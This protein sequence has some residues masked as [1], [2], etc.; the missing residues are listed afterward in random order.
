MLLN[1]VVS[2]STEVAS[3]RSRTAKARS[4]A[5]LLRAPP[6]I[7]RIVVPWLAGEMRQGRIGV[8]YSAIGAALETPSAAEPRWT[9]AEV[10]EIDTRDLLKHLYSLA[11][12]QA[13]D[14]K[15]GT[16]RLHDVMRKYLTQ[17]Q[18]SE[19]LKGLH[20]QFVEAYDAAS[21]PDIEDG[22]ERRYFYTWFPTHLHGYTPSARRTG[23]HH[24]T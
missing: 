18:A 14:L 7:L 10:D 16:V 20:H 23:H 24:P 21:G 22:E 12:L 8:G 4:L 13:L 15:R 5:A 9:V 17:K 2:T 1:D 6:E 3:T 19:A 11:L